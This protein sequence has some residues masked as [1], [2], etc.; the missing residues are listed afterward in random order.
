[1]NETVNDRNA[2]MNDRFYRGADLSTLEEVERCGGR[3]FD[4]GREDDAMRILRRH[5][6]NLVR[7]RLWNDPYGPNGEPYGAG[8]CSLP[9]VVRLARRARAL[10]MDVMLSFHYSDFWADPGKQLIPRAWRRL[11]ADALADAV[12]AYTASVLE[13]FAANGVTPRLA[14][15]GN[16]LTNGLLWPHGQTPRF[17]RIARYVSAGLAAIRAHDS[18]IQT[19]LHLD[20]GGSAALYRDWFDRYFACGG[21][22]F[23]VIG[24]SY[25]P[26]WHGTMDMLRENMAVVSGRY[27]RDVLIVETSMGFTLRDYASCEALP[28]DRRKGPAATERLA[29]SVAWPM[30]PAG[31]ARFL[32][33]LTA[34]VRQV[35]GGRGRGVVWWEPAWLPVPGSGWANEAALPYIGDPGPG[36]N[37]W[38]NQTLFD[39]KGNVL[40]AL[41]RWKD[42]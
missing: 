31:Q 25:Y 15:P 13:T 27:D 6:V 34:S 37:E 36:G 20:N 24:M 22:D 18:T 17:D 7:L 16:E 26:F 39:Y 10:G 19:V 14:A 40:P 9:R 3:F 21:A 29:A 4:D 33:E 5:G 12:Y 38:A 8:T 41:R 35:P 28:P 1:M 32:R 30:T 11:D 2:T 23:D 42:M